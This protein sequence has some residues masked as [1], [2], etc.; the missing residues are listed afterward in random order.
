MRLSYGLIFTVLFIWIPAQVSAQALSCAAVF[1]EALAASAESCGNLAGGIACYGTGNIESSLIDSTASFAASGDQMALVELSSLSTNGADL[2]AASYGLA[3][4]QLDDEISATITLLGDGV[5]AWDDTA[6]R[7]YQGLLYTRANPTA[8]TCADAPN[9]LIIKTTENQPIDFLVNEAEL[10]IAGQV[11]FNWQNQNSLTATVIEGTLTIFDG[12]ETSAG[13]TISAVTLNE[14]NILFW[15]APRANEADENALIQAANDL[16]VAF[17]GEETSGVCVSDEM[18][19][20]ADGETLFIIA[21]RY[22]LTV[23]QLVVANNITDRNFISVGQTLALPCASDNATVAEATPEP[24]SAESTPEATA[25]VEAP[26]TPETTVEAPSET[27]ANS[28]GCTPTTHLVVSGDNVFRLAMT[29]N[30]TIDAITEANNLLSPQ[31]IVAGQ[32]LVI[33]C[34]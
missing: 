10:T 29:Y 5:L 24:S 15:S 14:G 27:A 11:V 31:Q 6:A 19:T 30:T 1:Q 8:E 32:E 3:Q 17:G 12:A 16:V 13:Q 33:P 2:A 7:P 34:A 18:H 22:N 20:V 4:L 23:D 21:Q 9:A 25:V 26:S 28:D